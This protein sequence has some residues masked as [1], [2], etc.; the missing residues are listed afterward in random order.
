VAETNSFLIAAIGKSTGRTGE[1][2]SRQRPQFWVQIFKRMNSTRF[3][4]LLFCFLFQGLS[5][6]TG[7]LPRRGLWHA[8]LRFAN[9]GLRVSNV[10]EGRAAQ[11]AGLQDGDLILTIN[12]LSIP[13]QPTRE[14]ITSALRAGVP[15]ALTLNRQG[16]ILEKT[17]TL[18]PYPKEQEPGLDFEYGSIRTGHGD[19]VATLVS[20]PAGAKGKLPAILFIQWLSCGAP[21]QYWRYKDGWTQMFQGLSK[22]GYL[23]YRVTKPGAGDSQGPHCGEYGFNYELETYRA[24]LRELRRRPDVDTSR[25]FLFGGSLGGSIAPIIAQGQNLK[26]IIVSGC[27]YKTW[28]EHMLHIE[29]NIAEL[30]GASPTEVNRRMAQWSQFYALYLNEK[31]TPEEIFKQR[32][33]LKPLWNEPPRHQ[34][35]RPVEFYMEVNEHNIAGYWEQLHLPVLVIYGEHDWI[36]AREDHQMIAADMNKRHPGFGTYLEIPGMDHQFMIFPS[37]QE[38]YSG[39]SRKF[40]PVVLEKAVEWLKRVEGGG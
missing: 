2:M 17:I 23:F 33:D 38:A 10:T 7:E 34:Y 28:Y 15:I 18:D 40:D 26:G 14:K 16:E 27:T 37:R 19:R 21:E 30:E 1:K 36:M 31:K 9:P 22:A 35:G 3:F 8:T 11:R 12:G 24:A 13:D 20:K 5:A 32:P 4:T 6:Q 39:E 25:I 29:R